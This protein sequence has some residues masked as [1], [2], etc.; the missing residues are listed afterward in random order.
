LLGAIDAGDPKAA[1]QLLPLV[2]GVIST[3]ISPVRIVGPIVPGLKPRINSNGHES[4]SVA[5]TVLFTSGVDPLCP[6]GICV[7]RVHWCAFVV[8]TI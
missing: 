5:P 8:E 3:G 7:I 4:E 2:Y 1:D 6:Q